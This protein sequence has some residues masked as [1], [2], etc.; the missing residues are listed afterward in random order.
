MDIDM[1]RGFL[2]ASWP[3]RPLSPPVNSA[4]WYFPFRSLN[5]TAYSVDLTPPPQTV[6]VR[7]LRDVAKDF[8][9]AIVLPDEAEAAVVPPGHGAPHATTAAGSSAAASVP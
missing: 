4:A 5:S 7:D 3:H 2:V 1:N 9:A 8:V 6:S